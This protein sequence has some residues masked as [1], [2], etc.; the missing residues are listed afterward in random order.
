ML[1]G[2]TVEPRF[3]AGTALV[4]LGILVVSTH[5]WIRGTLATILRAGRAA[6]RNGPLSAGGAQRDSSQRS[7]SSPSAP[8]SRPP[9]SRR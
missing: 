3:V 8:S 2:E 6:K 5:A 9:H 7:R 4:L 1:L